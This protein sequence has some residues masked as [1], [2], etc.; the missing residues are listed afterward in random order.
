MFYK[1]TVEIEVRPNRIV[2]QLI[3]SGI[4]TIPEVLTV[5]KCGCV[6]AKPQL[7]QFDRYA[8]FHTALEY[9]FVEEAGHF[10]AI[11]PDT[12]IETLRFS[13]SG[14]VDNTEQLVHII[15][16]TFASIKNLYVVSFGLIETCD[17]TD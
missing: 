17:G 15:L 5:C 4:P 10:F 9:E 3:K 13:L 2:A 11:E 1:T 16:E 14:V 7:F 12:D 8:H 6:Y